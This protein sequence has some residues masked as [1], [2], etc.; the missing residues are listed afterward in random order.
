[1]FG[2][3]LELYVFD[4]VPEINIFNDPKDFRAPPVP[5]RAADQP[6]LSRPA[7]VARLAVPGGQHDRAAH[8]GHAGIVEQRRVADLMREAERR[9]MLN[10]KN[11]YHDAR[12]VK[13]KKGRTTKSGT[14]ENTGVKG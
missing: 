3:P 2:K 8:A 4:E 11:C 12:V 6:F 9:G 14:P 7:L 5:G 1:M 10:L 13:S